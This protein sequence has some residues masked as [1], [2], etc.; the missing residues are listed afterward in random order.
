MQQLGVKPDT[1]EFESLMDF[2]ATGGRYPAALHSS[3][4]PELVSRVVDE[5]RRKVEEP[6]AQL[7]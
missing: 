7:H 5:A 4:D 2:I 3:L 6:V 1:E